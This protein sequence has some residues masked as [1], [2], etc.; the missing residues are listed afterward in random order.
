MN[1]VIAMLKL[2]RKPLIGISAAVL[3]ILAA[4]N[5]FSGLGSEGI[6][7]YDES[8]HGISACEMME[9]GNFIVNTYNFERD[10]YNVKPVL[11][12]YNNLIGMALFGRNIFGIRVFSAFSCLIIAALMF[13]LLYR[14][15]GTAAALAGTAFFIVSPTN[16]THGFRTGDPDAA[17][18]LF[19][20][21]SLFCL[22]FSVRR[23]RL[24]YPAAFFLGL[25]FLTKS[26]HVGVPGILTL[27]FVAF[28]FKKYSWREL[29]LAAAIGAAPVLLWALLRFHAD[30]WNFFHNMMERDLLGRLENGHLCEH[31]GEPWYSYLSILNHYLIVIPMAIIAASAVIGIVFRGKMCFAAPYCKLG[32]W[33]VFFFLFSLV[34][35]SACRVKLPW[36]IFPAVSLYLPLVFGV[37]FQFA[38]NWIADTAA[39][40]RGVLFYLPPAAIAIACIVWLCIGEGK[41]IRN[42]VKMERQYDILTADNGGKNIRG[43]TLC[44]MSQDGNPC[45]PEPNMLLVIR[46]LDAKV[47]GKEVEEYRKD[48]DCEYLICTF[49]DIRD[50]AKLRRLAEET[51]IRYSLHL[52]RCTDRHA[53]YSR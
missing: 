47:I 39:K 19:C 50:D 44:C 8:R 31:V 10:Y 40:Q 18:M 23:S 4:V 7:R 42:I 22:W 35:F 16:W 1:K 52:I 11:S 36:Y 28:H 37:A 6:Y 25:A 15:A 20:F 29:V 9:S 24:L 53:L 38:F 30:G 12:F 32:G 14:A 5:L 26:F 46:F 21:A 45:L 2:H 49:G 51:A 33:A 17:F 43:K 3:V 27:I 48:P 34:L 13:I 41:A